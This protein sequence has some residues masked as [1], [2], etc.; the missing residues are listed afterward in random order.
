M[1][2]EIGMEKNAGEF[3]FSGPSHPKPSWIWSE[4]LLYSSTSVC[5]L[6]KMDCYCSG[7]LLRSAQLTPAVNFTVKYMTRERATTP[8][9][10]SSFCS[11]A[12][13]SEAFAYPHLSRMRTRR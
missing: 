7:S 10:L 13:R 4:Q 1:T 12:P 9:C 3:G 8:E 11:A 5:V 6:K 2:K